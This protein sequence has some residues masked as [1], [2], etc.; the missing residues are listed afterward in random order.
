MKI[1]TRDDTNHNT[2]YVTIADYR[3]LEMHLQQ[4]QVECNIRMEV[5]S[6]LEKEKYA[7]DT[8]LYWMK[9]NLKFAAVADALIKCG[10]IHHEAIDDAQGYDN[11]VTRDAVSALCDILANVPHHLP[12]KAGTPDAQHQ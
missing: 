7:S 10:I 4:K 5:Q 2:E 6:R 3:L 8:D 9:Q 11:G 12:R 1:L